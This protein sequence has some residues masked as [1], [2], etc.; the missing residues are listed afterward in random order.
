V[1]EEGV[2]EEE[3][4]AELFFIKAKQCC[5]LLAPKLYPPNTYELFSGFTFTYLP[6]ILNPWKGADA[7]KNIRGLPA[8][9]QSQPAGAAPVGAASALTLYGFIPVSTRTVVVTV[10]V[11]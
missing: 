2:G 4:V 1:A 10:V 11:Q 6:P 5:C 7:S 3:A 8:G 9:L